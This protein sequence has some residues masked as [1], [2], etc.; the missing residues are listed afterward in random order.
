MAEES[1]AERL[2]RLR[3]DP[4]KAEESPDKP[5]DEPP[6]KGAPEWLRE[7]LERR[8]AQ[9]GARR[10]ERFGSPP[11]PALDPRHIK[12]EGTPRGLV[13]REGPMGAFAERLTVRPARE[14]HGH[15]RFDEV[16]AA[17][18][19]AELARDPALEALEPRACV[20]LDIET[21]GLSGGAGTWPFMVALGTFVGDQFELW[22]G[23]MRDPGEEPGLLEETA[24]RIAA[25]G[26]IVSFFG[27]SFDRHRL[28]DKMRQHG[29][30]S[31]FD[32]RPHLDLYHPLNRLYTRRAIWQRLTGADAELAPAGFSDGRLGT[33]ERELCG[34]ERGLDLS[35]AHAPAAW[36]DFLGGRPHLLEEVFRHNALDVW[37]LATL[38][39][40]LGRA[41]D[42]RRVDGTPL[43]G[44]R[45]ARQLGL[46]SLARD[47]CQRGRE[48]EH[49][50]EAR[51]ELLAA[52]AT[53][54]VGLG[55]WRADAQRLGGES[56][57][58]LAAY[59]DLLEHPALP[60]RDR[61]RAATERAKLLEH[62]SHDPEAA[63]G[64]C[65]V[66]RAAA[67]RGRLGDRFLADLDK[68]ALR[69][70]RK[71]SEVRSS[72]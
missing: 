59:S 43:S 67:V 9:V 41:R 19:L 42:E 6:Q 27:K 25:S 48:L 10:R 56:E 18:G 3:R 38:L 62:H 64:A 20:Y 54:P 55:L 50:D 51:R 1:F 11:A 26:G 66:A 34:L 39:A 72:G 15:Y 16:D 49:L 69:L 36:F 31:P 58:A 68:R 65:E 46:A 24:R 60:E 61:A 4:P 23:F 5:A 53:E 44:P 47:A 33:M 17:E 40:H 70:A 2:R 14:C 32:G 7:R 13:G 63:L 45:L 12:A 29:I 30:A 71:L 37:S 21:T 8:R 52:S 22:Q 57:A 28:E 35:G